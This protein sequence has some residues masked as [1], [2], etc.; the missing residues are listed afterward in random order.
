MALKFHVQAVAENL[1]Q[2]GEPLDGTLGLFLAE[3]LVDRSQRPARQCDETGGRLLQP[4]DRDVRR[5]VGRGI[6]EQHPRQLH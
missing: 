1:L 5:L 4:C 6:E 3:R 2:G